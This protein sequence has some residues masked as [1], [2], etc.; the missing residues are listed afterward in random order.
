MAGAFGVTR[1]HLCLLAL[2]AAPLA[3]L[4]VEPWVYLAPARLCLLASLGCLW[5][6]AA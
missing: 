3:A 1:P 2:C 4:A 5:W 6:D